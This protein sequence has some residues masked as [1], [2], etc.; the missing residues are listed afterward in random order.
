MAKLE[1]RRIAGL[2][3]H[4][5]VPDQE[6]KVVAVLCHGF[7]APGDDLVPLAAQLLDG[8]P[9]LLSH[10][11]IA[12][13]AAPLDLGP[14]GLPGGRAWW[15]VNIEQLSRETEQGEIEKHK[16]PELPE[17]RAQVNA[18]IDEVMQETGVPI[19]KFV[20]GGFSQGSMIATDVALTRPEAP[21]G[22]IIWSGT[23]I[24]RGD[25]ESGA[26]RLKD[27][28]VVQT[29]GRNDPI[30]SYSAAVQLREFLKSQGADLNFISFHGPHTITIEGLQAAGHLC[31]R[32]LD[33]SG[34][35]IPSA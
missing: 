22:L 10:L 18:L 32:L 12:V 14:Y 2:D 19:S 6:P 26:E 3:S 30:L 15:P 21:G 5:F 17:A 25:W 9:Y 33:P 8:N 34:D 16:P 11:M 29:H 23:L 13:P 7:G 20:L 1:A 28:P 27:L 31:E 4:V 35:G 24:N